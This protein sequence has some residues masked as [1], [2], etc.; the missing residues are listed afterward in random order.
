MDIDFPKLEKKL[1]ELFSK[2]APGESNPLMA[3]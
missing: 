1:T 3:R 2:P